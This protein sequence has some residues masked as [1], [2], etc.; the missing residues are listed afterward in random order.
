[1]G[2]R[3]GVTVKRTLENLS[4]G[5]WVLGQGQVSRKALQVLAGK[6]VHAL[7]FRRPLFSCY[8]E[9]WRLIAGPEDH[10]YLTA[11]ACVEIFASL[12]LSPLRFTDWRAEVDPYVMASDA[13]ETGGAFSVAKRL[14]HKG[15]KIASSLGA[16]DEG[17]RNGVVVF[18]FFAGIGGLLRSLERAGLKWEHHVV[19]EQDKKCRRVSDALGLREAS[20]RTSRSC[21][22]K[23]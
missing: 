10:P 17:R 4:L 14:S 8:S 9:L 1:M 6:E 3:V 15:V 13:S 18:D 22:R 16:R 20:S 7:Q 11:K 2:R 21:Q 23:K 5:L 12:C 19:I